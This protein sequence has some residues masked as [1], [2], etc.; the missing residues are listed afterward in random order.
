LSATNSNLASLSTSV[1]PLVAASNAAAAQGGTLLGTAIGGGTGGT[2]Q[3]QGGKFGNTSV[4]TVN[5]A[6]MTTANGMDT[7]ATGLGAQAGSPNGP[8]ADGA[9][10]YG[11]YAQALSPNTTA[12][13]FRAVATHAGSVAIGHQAQAIADPATAIGDNSL[14]SGNDSLAVGASAQA[15]AN[16]A[17]ALGAFSVAD[18]PNTVSVGTPG[19]ERRITNVAPGVLP[20]DAVN[21]S[22]LRDVSRVAYSGVAMSMA[23][24][25]AVMPPLEPGEKGVGV[26]IG[27]Y[28]G[29]TALGFQFKA[30]SASGESAWGVGISTTGKEWGLQ[31]GFG[32]K[33]K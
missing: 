22:Q 1:Q 21:V 18:Q 14:A 28:K 13:G 32:V 24:A 31:A 30:L 12:I 27:T 29:Y 16:R 20:T 8:P 7:T 23:M 10:A 19:A 4:T 26:G 33:W 2:V 25:G 6:G 11:A 5:A 15:T 9:T 17:V 3:T